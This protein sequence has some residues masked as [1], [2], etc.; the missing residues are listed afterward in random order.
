MQ[1]ITVRYLAPTSYR[2]ARYVAEA[3][4]GRLVLPE[5][6]GKNP[7]ENAARAA[8]ALAQ[9]YEWNYGAWVGGETRAG[10]AFVCVNPTSPSFKLPRG[11]A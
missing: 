11:E 4:A 7:E 5:D 6:Y 8:M 9:K 3:Q 2:G 1:S 10:W